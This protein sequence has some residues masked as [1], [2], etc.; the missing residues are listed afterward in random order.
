MKTEID[1]LAKEVEAKVIAWRRDIHQH[2]ELS[3][4]EFRTG[5]LVARHLQDLGLEVRTDVARTGVIGL[6][7]GKKKGAV[8]ALR[9]DM[10]ALPVSEKTKAPYASKTEGV[11]HACGHDCHT[12]ILM[13]TAH[14]LSRMRDKIA[15]SVKFLFQPS[16]E[17]PP[18][19]EEGGALLMIKEG[20]LKDP[21]PD[22]II[23]LHVG[24]FPGG[25]FLY[26]SGPFM[27]SGDI[28]NI[29]VQGSQTHGAMP[30]QGVDPVV[31]AA[32][33][34][35]GL[36][37]IVSRQ[38]DLTRT[39]AVI[40]IGK[41]NGGERFN[42]LPQKVEMTGTIR[43]ADNDIR[44]EIF[45]KVKNTAQ[46]IA[47]SAGATAAVTIKRAFALTFN[48]PALTVQMVSTFQKLARREDIVEI[49]LLTGSED[50]SFYQEK[51]PGF[52]FFM[53]V[54]PPGGNIIPIHS[55]FFDVDEKALI[56]GVR[57]LA[58]S[59]VDFLNAKQ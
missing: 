3:N 13:G 29:V 52:F 15:G 44:E 40:S 58:H 8:V 42:I 45:R 39:P 50:F 43:V 27:A 41:I 22:A 11:M 2:P 21:T 28:L 24:R 49:P 10:D 56:T 47:K 12:S 34:I 17:G 57:A 14:V 48:D 1:R 26:R 16:E 20:A 54:A 38:I 33:I 55:P 46:M 51:V 25:V 53:N 5:K 31:V 9:A 35:V 7:H 36:Q 4:R 19:G 18:E 30:W 32:Q 59:A 6:L 23:G 37:S